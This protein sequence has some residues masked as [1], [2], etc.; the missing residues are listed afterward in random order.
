MTGRHEVLCKYI[1]V[2]NSEEGLGKS[3][4]K[5]VDSKNIVEKG[6]RGQ[7]ALQND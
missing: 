2:P 6:C 5:K 7:K 3:L 1:G 4:Q